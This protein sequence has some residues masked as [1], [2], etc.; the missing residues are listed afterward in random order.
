MIWKFK[1]YEFKKP[2]S[3]AGY[4]IVTGGSLVLYTYF[5]FKAVFTKNM[6]FINMNVNKNK[7]Y[8]EKYAHI[9]LDSPT[10]LFLK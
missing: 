10:V 9:I 1:I 4:L 8:I 7:I 3:G 2:P 6:C 5:Y